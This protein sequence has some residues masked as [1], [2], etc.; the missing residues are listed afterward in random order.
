MTYANLT[1]Q[2]IIVQ[3]NHTEKEI[4]YVSS[5]LNNALCVGNVSS[6]ICLQTRLDRFNN[7]L[8]LLK[9]KLA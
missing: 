7:K 4:S 8:N 2:D 9:I 1:P 5:C 6:I 3:I